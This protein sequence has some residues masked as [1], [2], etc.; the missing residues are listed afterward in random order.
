MRATLGTGALL[1]SP[2]VLL[3]RLTT[4]AATVGCALAVVPAPA[5]AARD[6]LVV[7]A[8]VG[9]VNVPACNDQV[10]KLCQ[11]LV[12]QRG[13]AA[14]RALNPDI[15]GFEEILPAAL[16]D[17]APSSMGSNL[18]STP[19]NPPSQV[20]RLLG[21]GYGQACDTRFGWECLAARD[22][23]AAI[24]RLETRPVLAACA[25][26][27]FTLN[28]GTLRMQGWP[29]TVAV[30][31]PD[32][33]QAE[34][35][36]AQITDLLSALPGA[37]PSLI[38]GDWNLDPFREDDASVRV[39]REQ[40]LRRYR[41]ASGRD[42]TF[43]PGAPSQSDPTG[44]RLDGDVAVDSGPLK[45]RTID[46]VLTRDGVTGG[47]EVQRIDGGGGMDH[48]AQVCRLRLG[49][50]VTPTLTLKRSGR[51]GLAAGLSPSP[52]WLKGFRVRTGGAAFTTGERFRRRAREVTITP[53]L[54]NG[55]GPTFTRRV[56]A[57]AKGCAKR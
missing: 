36:A 32:S 12:E 11:R 22:G 29:V 56:A 28:A 13:A 30:A 4:I 14:L 44:T 3:R 8:N 16:C 27:G 9:N 55:D 50:E 24:E 21:D 7:Q 42:I 19:L 52:P 35:R 41:S 46:H 47:C 57:P 26:E 31:H 39:W 34:C 48:R 40:V 20:T 23:V 37:G 17:R 45:Q 25:D 54:A 10:F 51:C 53:V 43:V 49:D 33:M 6:L 15:V 1:G 2:T 18:C 5:S 38:L